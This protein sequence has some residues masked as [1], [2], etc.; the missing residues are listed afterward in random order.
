[1]N[2]SLH[3][4]QTQSRN[5]PVIKMTG[6][7]KIQNIIQNSD[8]NFAVSQDLK[9]ESFHSEES[10]NYQHTVKIQWIQ[11]WA[12]TNKNAIN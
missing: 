8:Q 9:T 3:G 6:M 5:I 4:I 10:I 2:K 11:S 7:K 12:P 1:M